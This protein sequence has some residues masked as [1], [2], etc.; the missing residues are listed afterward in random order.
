MLARLVLFP[1]IL[2]ITAADA[3]KEDTRKQEIEMLQGPWVLVGGEEKGV[4][5]SEEDAK[6]QNQRLIFKGE[7]VTMLRDGEDLGTFKFE[8]DPSKKPASFDIIYTDIHRNHAIYALEGDFLKMCVSR[9]YNP[10]TSD[11]RPIKFTSKRE[12][13]KD[14][15]GLVYV[16][17]KRKQL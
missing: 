3:P 13:N 8:I 1:V 17:Y 5:L 4:I 10:N 15:P 2:C 14:L 7:K 6:E 16:I 12:E 11:E 9:K